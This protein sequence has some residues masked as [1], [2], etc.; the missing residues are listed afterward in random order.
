MASLVFFAGS[1]AH[2]QE[3]ETAPIPPSSS[4]PAP[5][6]D[7]RAPA[8]PS[9][10]AGSSGATTPSGSGASPSENAATSASEP[11]APSEIDAKPAEPAASKQESTAEI[12]VVGTR[13][14]KTA[15]SAHV[16][17]KK[18][19]ERFSY[20]DPTA[21]LRSVPGVYSRGEDGMG[22]RPNIGIRGVNPDRSKKLTIM[23]DGVLVAPATYSAPAAYYFPLMQRIER[24][25]V[26]KGPGAIS[27]GPQTVGGAINLMTRAIPAGTAGMADVGLGQYGYNKLHGYF[28]TSDE[29]T[30]FLVEAAHLGTDGFKELPNGGDTGFYRNEAM[31]KARY[32]PDPHS[33]TP[34]EFLFKFNYSD[35][36]SNETYLGITDADFRAN[37]LQRYGA[38]QLDRM[39]NFRTGISLTHTIEPVRKMTITTT[40]YRNDFYRVWRK[41]NGFRGADLFNVLRSPNDP[42]NAVFAAVISGKADSSSASETLVIGP[43]QRDFVSQGIQSVV[44]WDVDTGPIQHKL[45]YG[46]RVHQ[47]RVERRHSEDPFR[48][49]SGQLV[50]EGGPTVVTAFNEASTEA[51]ALHVADAMTW[52]RLTVTPGLRIE[53]MRSAFIDRAAK[54]EE[55]ALSNAFL[56]GVGLFYSFTDVLGAFAGAYRGFSPT[57][58]GSP[59][60]VKP[61][62]STNYEGGARWYDRI[63]R[64]EAIGFYN[65]YSNITDVCTF[66][67]G[68]VQENVDRQYDGGE[69]RI[70]GVEGFAQIAPQIGEVTMPFTAAYTFTRA[71]FLTNFHSE[72]P[73][74]GDVVKGDERPSVPRHQLNASIGVESRY[75]GGAFGATYVSAMREEAGKEPVL[76]TLHTDDQ[77]VF[78]VSAN[79]RP[80]KPLMIYA[81]VRNLF[82]DH[83][84]VSHR[85]FGARPN[86]PRWAQL[87]LKAT[88]D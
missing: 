24:I 8:P 12:S 85:P 4:E 81:N 82:D 53:A 9:N 1:Y 34:S 25:I 35:E 63:V 43:N 84:I 68:C 78:D 57:A 54:T 20:D 73:I 76:D 51:L 30:G 40:A 5:P 47:D 13:V 66:S 41:V 36:V 45:E 28:G 72:D 48:L 21:A 65:D 79:V 42:R 23:E 46:M 22:L 70:Y 6:S 3:P 64:V 18:D 69:A 88:F 77:L 33:R 83:S 55:R 61:E 52:K 67:S 31:F 56:P 27:Y 32:V 14:G 75:A 37:P 19:L 59:S 2:A 39:K 29:T 49:I 60:S 17:R 11:P 10:P 15:G 86:A 71:E 74:F 87:G 26:V 80:W 50:P 44:R 7:S 58:P 16:V 38:S 62:F